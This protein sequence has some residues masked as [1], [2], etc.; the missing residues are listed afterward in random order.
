MFLGMRHMA[1]TSSKQKTSQNWKSSRKRPAG[2]LGD[3]RIIVL[4]IMVFYIAGSAL[5]QSQPSVPLMVTAFAKNAGIST[6][7]IKGNVSYNRGKRI[8]HVPGQ[9]DY[10]RTVITK[11]RGERWF[12]SESEARAAGWRKARR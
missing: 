3:S 7:N 9:K 4:I 1:G 5:F 2:L 12:C 6:C 8:F 10:G 11:H